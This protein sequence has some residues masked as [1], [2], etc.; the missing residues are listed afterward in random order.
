MVTTISDIWRYDG[1]KWFKDTTIVPD[2]YQRI[3]FEDIFGYKN[4]MYAVGIAE[5]ADGDYKGIIVHYDG[6]KWSIINTPQIKVYFIRLMFLQGGDILIKGQDFLEPNDPCRLYKLKDTT[7]TLIQKSTTDFF[8]GILNNTMCVSNDKNIFTYNNGSLTQIID[9]TNT[10]YVG[11]I[12]GRSEKDFFSA[13]EGWNLGHYNGTNE[14]DIYNIN[15][16]LA[17]GII[18][19]KDVFFLCSTLDNVYYVLHGKLK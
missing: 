19:S 10:D 11:S 6:E 16:Y 14:I 15:G 3:L 18:F 4:N 17:D 9:L 8:L 5:K 7:L 13:N 2:G 12:Y 1:T